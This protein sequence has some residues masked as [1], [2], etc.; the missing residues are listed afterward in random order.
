MRILYLI[1]TVLSATGQEHLS[2]LTAT[3]L[4]DSSH[5]IV[6][7][8]RT[9]RRFIRTVNAHY[10]LDSACFIPMNKHQDYQ[11]E[12]SELDSW[13]KSGVN[14]ALL[15]DAGSPCI[16]DP[17]A[18]YVDKARRSDY[19]VKPLAGPSSIIMALMASGL[20]GQRFCFHG[21]LPIDKVE[22]KKALATLSQAAAKKGYTQVF[23]ET[24]Y[25]NQSTYN[26]LLESLPS[27]MRLCI[28]S[29]I[30]GEK[31]RIDTREIKRWPRE[32][33]LGK[34]PTVFLVGK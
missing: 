4:S 8:L 12:D 15:S 31:E 6:E 24:P 34:V 28:A 1:P 2:P 5:F 17:G 13:I 27:H 22:L 11:T 9:A 10:D 30:T 29:D 25:R 18:W 14:I 20:E 21:Y 3:V 16:A 32:L 7:N 23:I 33:I 19:T 26:T